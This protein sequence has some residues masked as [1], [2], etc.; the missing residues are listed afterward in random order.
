MSPAGQRR[1]GHIPQTPDKLKGYHQV[2]GIWIMV[3]DKGEFKKSVLFDKPITAYPCVHFV[4]QF[5][6]PV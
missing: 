3:Q 5:P 6:Q 4:D 2:L 1:A